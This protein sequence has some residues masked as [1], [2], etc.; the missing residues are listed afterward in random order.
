MV[1][2]QISETVITESREWVIGSRVRKIGGAIYDLQ[3]DNP[4]FWIMAKS[5]INNDKT[6]FQFSTFD[7]SEEAAIAIVRAVGYGLLLLVLC[8][9]VAL[10]IPL[11]LMN[12]AW[13]FQ[14]FGQLVERVPVP[15]IGFAMA[16]WGGLINRNQREINFLKL[17]SLLTLA[18]GVGFYLLV[19]L[20][21]TN[22]IRLQKQSTT[23]IE[24]ALKQQ[25]SQAD[26]FGQKIDQAN[27][28]Q[29]NQLLRAQGV[30]PPNQP[31]PQIKDELRS[32][33]TQSKEQ[34]KSQA[35]FTLESRKLLL[36]KSSVKW[37]IGAIV[38]GSLFLYLWKATR[39]V[40]EA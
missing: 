21:V 12:P 9:W 8:D 30:N 22:T 31:L 27:S 20:G 4:S 15:L 24:S 13:E 35:K 29:I 40:R 2:K 7:G 26:V 18:L 6:K 37:N 36:L 3:L 5:D 10:F 39:W 11:D 17:L 33:L 14:T 1:E 16:F 38:A 25:I 28:E 34:I 32:R 23:Q 19:P